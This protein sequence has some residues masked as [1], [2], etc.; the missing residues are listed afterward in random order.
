MIQVVKAFI[1]NDKDQFLLI[2]R[3]AD[4]TH[5]GKWETPGGGIEKGENA[6]MASHREVLE[7]SG[8]DVD[9]LVFDGRVEL[10]DDQSGELMDV[11]LTSLETPMVNPQV[12]LSDNPDHTEYVWLHY[13]QL[14]EFLLS[15]KEIDR[16]TLTQIIAKYS[17]LN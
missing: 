6:L 3:A 4:D 7:E 11:L 16:W 13:S 1:E 8:L 2:K 10:T 5:G 15:G 14:G 9:R 17:E 12:D